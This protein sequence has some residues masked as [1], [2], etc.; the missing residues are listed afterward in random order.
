MAIA[1]RKIN[2]EMPVDI[3]VVEEVHAPRESTFT[4]LRPD[5]PVES[6]IKYVSGYPW[7]VTY[8]GQ[9]LNTQ[10]VVNHFDIKQGDLSQSYIEVNDLVVK[11]QSPL[12]HNYDPEQGESV[13]SGTSI[14]P[15]SIRPNPGDIFIANVDTGEDVIFVVNNVNR[16]TQRK[17]T[18][19]EIEYSSL[20]FIND[21]PEFLDKLK[22]RINESYY[23]DSNL[24]ANGKNTFVT[25]E[26]KYHI[27]KLR[28][29]IYTTQEY[30]FRMFKQSKTSSLAIPSL[31]DFAYDQILVDFIMRTVDVSDFNNTNMF[32]YSNYSDGY[33][34][35]TILDRLISGN[36]PNKNNLTDRIGF[37]TSSAFFRSSNLHTPYFL[38]VGYLSHPV[39]SDRNFM[40]KGG[41][42]N[43]I[44][45]FPNIDIRDERNYRE[46]CITVPVYGTEGTVIKKLLPSL[47]DEDFYIVSEAFY[48]YLY[49]GEGEEDI[50]FLELLIYRYFNNIV[51]SREDVFKCFKEWESWSYLH[52]FYLLPVLWLLTKRAL[53][54]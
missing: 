45:E 15:L 46:E 42:G 34:R 32:N 36:K 18:L 37:F 8:Y 4:S 48:K 54:S 20:A 23:Y 14:V 30:Y 21:N 1:S 13:L 7:T 41:L 10:S 40:V 9:L 49:T 33:L 25:K 43:F 31:G 50:S 44:N 38:G 29:Y 19:Y 39:D 27:D 28:A 26:D 11:V 53:N 24:D 17:N 5:T 22:K 2:R 16:L 6:L 35:D 12:S 52:Q 3:P 51:V 47:F